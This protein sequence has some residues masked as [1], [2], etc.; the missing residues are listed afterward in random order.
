MQSLKHTKVD[1][2]FYLAMSHIDY[3]CQ[4][5]CSQIA[6]IQWANLESKL[7]VLLAKHNFVC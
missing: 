3:Y 1:V 5:D 7:A 4:I 6:S 2:Q